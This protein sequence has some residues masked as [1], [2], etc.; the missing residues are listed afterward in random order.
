MLRNNW[1]LPS[2]KTSF[3]TIAY[4]DDIRWGKNNIYCPKYT[5]VKVR[6]CP[7]KPL[8]DEIVAELDKVLKAKKK[9]IGEINEKNM[10]NRQ[11]M[12]DVISTL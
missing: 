9:Y 7:I 5:D 6:P 2:L 12:L 4:M 10:P 3:C 8:K 11:W 1:Y